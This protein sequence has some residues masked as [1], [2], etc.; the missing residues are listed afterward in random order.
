MKRDLVDKLIQIAYL[1]G[2]ITTHGLY[3]QVAGRRK[4]TSVAA[5][6]S[7]K[8]LIERLE[9][10]LRGDTRLQEEYLTIGGFLKTLRSG[11]SVGSQ[12]IFTRLGVSRNL[13]RMIEHDRVSPLRIPV[14]VWRRFQ[15]IFNLPVDALAGMIRRT[16]QLVLF[17]PAFNS[18]LARYDARKSKPVK[19]RTVELAAT[20]LFVRARFELS[21]EEEKKIQELVDSI[22]RVD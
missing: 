22:A 1:E 13:Y 12:E 19:R 14:N 15:G 2:V 6:A 5:A 11:T 4:T 21:A 7:K 20:E 3:E 17:R 10:A 9:K 16:Y 8:R 18:T